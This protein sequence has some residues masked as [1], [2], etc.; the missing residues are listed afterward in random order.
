[1]MIAREYVR[2][3]LERSEHLGTLALDWYRALSKPGKLA[4]WL[5][6]SLH[7]VLGALFWLIGPE[8]IFAWFARLADDVRETPNGWWILSLVIV[9]TSIPPLVGYGTAQTLVGF[10][11]GV[12]PGFWISAASCLV[13]GAVA[14]LVVRRLIGLFAP[15][16]QR[17]KTFAALSRAVRV[18]GL[19]L[20]VLLR[21][22]PFP[23]P[24]SNAFFASIETV[25]LQEFMLATLA[26][27]PK[28][29]LHVFIGH[30]TY[31]FADPTSRHKMD[32]TTRWI[33]GVF[34][35]AGTLL[36]MG[37]S[38]Y[39][40]KVGTVF[41]LTMRYVEEAAE[42]EEEQ[43]ALEAGL[44]QDVDELLEEDGAP[45]GDGDD[46]GTSQHAASAAGRPL[47]SAYDASPRVPEGPLLDVAD[48]D[49]SRPPP[50]TSRTNQLPPPAE[51]DGDDDDGGGGWG[52]AFS[53]YSAPRE[54]ARASIELD[55]RTGTAGFG[56]AGIERGVGHSRGDSAAWGLEEDEAALL[57]DVQ[58][59]PPVGVDLG[60]DRK[61]R[62][63]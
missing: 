33:N 61:E 53:D 40:Y 21:L 48:D 18:K 50:S 37:T 60:R 39:L 25:S 26:I 15:Y 31:L 59:S 9:V 63:D 49:D 32:S 11:Y 14:F 19:P 62:I 2:L 47:A 24:Y 23:Y 16:I 55:S 5:W 36:G 7:L 20:I 1:M 41:P 27:T 52:D 10:A 42:G 13:G 30:R 22:C 58:A 45:Q 17:D 28:L 46:D 6:A 38:W 29:L 51:E 35:V 34:M 57:D 8:R 3:A 54:Q 43:D 12:L 4:V 56:P 44:L